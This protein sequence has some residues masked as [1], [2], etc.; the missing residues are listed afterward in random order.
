MQQSVVRFAL[1]ALAALLA[2][3]ALAVERPDCDRP[4][5]LALH[6]HGLLYSNQSGEGID[7]DFAD[8]LIR[9][10]GCKFSVTVMPRG[11]IWQLIETGALDFSLSGITNEARDGFASFAWYFSNKYYLLVRKDAAVRRLDDF[12]GNRALKLGVIRSFRYSPTANRLVDRLDAE[13]RVSYSTSLDPLYQILLG[14]RVQGMIIEP[15][16]YPALE[17]GALRDQTTIVEFDD[18]PVPHGLIMS[19]KALSVPQQLAWRALVDGMRADG[20]V[21]RIFEK[22]F[23]AELAR[24]LTKF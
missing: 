14:N 8:E 11:R 22:Y 20:T 9:R 4:M 16:D 7:K 18:P 5:S 17:G 3:P 10:S 1:F 19:K 13:Q 12:E 24:T 2:G 6:D 15:F 21:Q 23:S